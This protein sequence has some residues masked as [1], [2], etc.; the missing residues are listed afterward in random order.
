MAF[1]RP[2]VTA[3]KGAGSQARQEEHEVDPARHRGR[4]ERRID[5]SSCARRDRHLGRGR[6]AGRAFGRRRHQPIQIP[7][8]ATPRTRD[9]ELP[10][11]EQTHPV[12]LLQEYCAVYAQVRR[13]SFVFKDY[14]DFAAAHSF[15]Y[16]FSNS[17]SG[18]VLF[19]SWTLTFYNVLFTVLPPVVLGV[20]D[21]VRP[22]FVPFSSDIC[23]DH[24]LQF[25]SARMLDRYPEQYQ[26]GQR[27]A[28][29]RCSTA[30]RR[31]TS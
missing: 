3:A 28:F 4:R 13:L 15:W 6:S 20:F 30:V 26:F 31:W 18:Q 7:H 10:A 17:F 27:N 2:S 1:R 9:M 25:V 19:E 21:Q 24:R 11:L 29:V 8:Q 23:A 16:A 14:A 5:D 12:Q 22:S